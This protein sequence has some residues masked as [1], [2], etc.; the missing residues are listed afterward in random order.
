MNLRV[1]LIITHALAVPGLSHNA[2]LH[3]YPTSTPAVFTSFTS[4]STAPGTS[5]VVNT[6]A[7]WAWA[8]EVENAATSSNAKHAT[9]TFN[10]ML[11]VASSEFWRAILQQLLFVSSSFLKER[12]PPGPLCSMVWRHPAQAF[13]RRA[14]HYRF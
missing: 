14:A 6:G 5:T 9:V 8:V 11:G 4:V 13:C 10:F 2:S 7:F 12:F 3:S 1:P